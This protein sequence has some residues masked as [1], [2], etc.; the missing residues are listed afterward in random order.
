MV[1]LRIAIADDNGDFRT[2][3]VRMLQLLGHEVPIAVGDGDELVD[4]CGRERVDLVFCDFH[5]PRMDGLAA[6]ELLAEKG[7]PV[8]LISGHDDAENIVVDREPIKQLLRKPASLEA[9][10]EAIENVVSGAWAAPVRE[11]R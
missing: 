2:V 8:V 1:S 7:I 4:C 5:L 9:I 10:R 11:P 6:A 3:L